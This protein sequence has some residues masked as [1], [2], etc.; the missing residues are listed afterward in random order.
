MNIR[1]FTTEDYEAHARVQNEVYSE[2]PTTVEEIRYDDETRDKKCRFQRYVIEHEGSIIGSGS[3]GHMS[4]LFHPHKYSVDVTIM[5][6]YQGHGFGKAMYQFLLD[7]LAPLEPVSLRA[8]AREDMARSM[9]FIHDRGFIEDERAWESRLDPTTV[10]FSPYEGLQERLAMEGIVIKTYAQ[11]KED[12][13]CHRKIWEMDNEISLDMPMPEPITLPDEEHFVNRVFNNPNLLPD[14][15]FIAMHGD[16]YIGCSTLW[17]SQGN[18]DL[19]TGLTGV[20]QP[21]RKRGIALAMKLRAVAYAQERG[22]RVVKTWNDQ[23][24]RNMLGINERLGFVKQPAWV[25]FK[26]PLRDET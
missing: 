10:D 2:Y 24:N 19:Y 12:P 16:E 6:E 25:G 5:P 14:A 3:F 26:K 8:F 17:S 13:D 15:F 9:R 4:F 23:T 21:Y 20:R 22:V 18:D 11:L 1:P 7:Q